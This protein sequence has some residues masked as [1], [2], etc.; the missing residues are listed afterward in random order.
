MN[1]RESIS[2][3]LIWAL[4]ALMLLTGC[5]VSA[6]IGETVCPFTEVGWKCSEKT[7][8][9]YET[10]DFTTYPS[11]YSGTTYNYH[12]DYMGHNGTIK[13][14]YD[15]NGDLKCIG[16]LYS[17]ENMEDLTEVF[18]MLYDECNEKYGDYDYVAPGGGVVGNAGGVWYRDEGNIVLSQMT[19]D[20]VLAVQ[21]TY[22]H[23]DVSRGGKE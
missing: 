18:D 8:K 20:D 16:W 14:M 21:C 10:G 9:A 6:K 12:K 11:V 2:V 5:S 15:N 7:L 23:P 1:R 3:L 17:A 22:L 13:Y 19:T 4:I